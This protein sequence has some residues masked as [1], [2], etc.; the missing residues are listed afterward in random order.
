MTMRLKLQF[1][2]KTKA[3]LSEGV[4]RLAERSGKCG[5]LEG[6]YVEKKKQQTRFLPVL[7]F[8]LRISGPA[9]LH[10]AV[11]SKTSHC[12]AGCPWPPTEHSHTRTAGELAKRRPK[13]SVFPSRPGRTLD[14]TAWSS[15]L[16]PNPWPHSISAGT[17]V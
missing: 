16:T 8:V 1:E 3:C 12:R 2:G 13:I 6:E 9:L 17:K 5:G 4:E 11:Q 14:R 15:V 7:P 10:T